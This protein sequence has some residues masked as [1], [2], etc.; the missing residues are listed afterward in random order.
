MNA[1]GAITYLAVI[2]AVSRDAGLDVI[3][4]SW[5]RFPRLGGVVLHLCRKRANFDLEIYVIL[6]S[7]WGA[8]IYMRCLPCVVEFKQ[9]SNGVDINRGEDATIKRSICI[10]VYFSLD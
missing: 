10:L 6:I 1:K 7:Q 3:N 8:P 2:R 5:Q 9:I 4:V